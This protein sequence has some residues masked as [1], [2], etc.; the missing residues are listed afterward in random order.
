MTDCNKIIDFNGLKSSKLKSLQLYGSNGISSFTSKLIIDDLDIIIN[1][2]T[3][4][5][6]GLDIVKNKDDSIL[7]DKLSQL[8]H[9]KSISLPSNM[10]TFE[11][12]AWLKSRLKNIEGLEPYLHYEYNNTYG[13]VG[14]RMPQNIKNKIKAEEYKVKFEKL[15]LKYDQENK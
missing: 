9:L 4:E 15:I 11:Q 8:T 3:L 7:L 2:K 10:F 6:L 12:F 14:K 13:I 1:L 5:E